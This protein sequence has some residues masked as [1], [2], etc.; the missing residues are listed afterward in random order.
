MDF[1]R[2]NGRVYLAFP[3]DGLYM[4][5]YMCLDSRFV[6]DFKNL[7]S[8]SLRPVFSPVSNARIM[9]ISPR[10]RTDGALGPPDGM[11]WDPKWREDACQDDALGKPVGYGEEYIT[12]DTWISGIAAI[13]CEIDRMQ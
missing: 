9:S 13:A 12:L 7:R 1:R 2:N 10:G 6:S 3:D 8:M 4:G 11:P 5:T